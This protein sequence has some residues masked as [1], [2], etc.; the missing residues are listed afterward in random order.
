MAALKY[1]LGRWRNEWHF[2]SKEKVDLKTTEEKTSAVSPRGQ[3]HGNN[4]L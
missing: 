3:D 1:R 4:K 2:R